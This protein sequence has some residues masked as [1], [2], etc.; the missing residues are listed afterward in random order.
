MMHGSTKLKKKKDLGNLWAKFF[1]VVWSETLNIIMD[2]VHV[3]KR[4]FIFV[5]KRE[6]EILLLSEWLLFI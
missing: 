2:E 3:S 1:Y 4:E 6:R 5:I